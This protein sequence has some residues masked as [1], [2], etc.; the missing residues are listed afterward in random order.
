MQGRIGQRGGNCG[1]GTSRRCLKQLSERCARVGKASRQ[2]ICTGP[3]V[4][5]PV[6]LQSSP[7][8]P[9][10]SYNSTRVTTPLA[11]GWNTLNCIIAL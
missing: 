9:V 8:K 10:V 5:D 6:S 3:G 4:Q 2:R 11:Q 7:Q 1:K